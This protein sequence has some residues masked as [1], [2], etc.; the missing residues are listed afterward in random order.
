MADVSAV[1]GVSVPALWVSMRVKE[2]GNLFIAGVAE[3]A[4]MPAQ[5]TSSPL[6]CTRAVQKRLAPPSQNCNIITLPDP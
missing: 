5:T 3:P 6:L 1:G 4:L 2:K